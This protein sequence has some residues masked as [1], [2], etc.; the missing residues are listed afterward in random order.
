MK[1]FNNFIISKKYKRSSLAIGNFD[2][3]HKGHQKVFKFSRKTKSKFG[4]L[5]F[6]TLPVMFFNKQIRNYYELYDPIKG[7]IPGLA[8]REIDIK[9]PWDPATY[10][11]G[12]TASPGTAWAEEHIGEV[13]WDLSTVR[14]LWYE[15]D[16]Q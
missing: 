12:P 5:N 13:W 3:V 15:Q 9:T 8:D 11:V 10:N 6:S 1:I 16:T 7:R 2:G 4:I 14:W